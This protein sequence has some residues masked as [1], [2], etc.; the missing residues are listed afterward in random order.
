MILYF[1]QAQKKQKYR[2]RFIKWIRYALIGSIGR[3]PLYLVKRYRNQA[4]TELPSMQIP[5]D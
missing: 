1:S 5:T 2:E 3:L 4:G